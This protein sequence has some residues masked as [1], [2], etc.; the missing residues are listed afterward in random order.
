LLSL[1]GL[2]QEF[3]TGG[4][5]R[6]SG[7]P[8][9]TFRIVIIWKSNSWNQGF[10]RKLDF[11]ILKMTKLCF[12]WSRGSRV[13]YFYWKGSRSPKRLRI[14]GLDYCCIKWSC[15]ITK[16]YSL[17]FFKR[18]TISGL[19]RGFEIHAFRSDAMLQAQAI[20]G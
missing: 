14:T 17:K 6:R 8:E 18:K 3:L 7:G 5:R 19:F 10:F 4:P 1:N 13:K 9:R 2:D 16:K 20:K 12:Y 11:L 15:L